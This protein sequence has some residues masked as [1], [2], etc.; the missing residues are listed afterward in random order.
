MT[1]PNLRPWWRAITFAGVIVFGSAAVVVGVVEV[2][3]QQIGRVG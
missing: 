2:V 1:D 3:A